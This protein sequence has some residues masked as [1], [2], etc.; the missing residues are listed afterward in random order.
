MKQ[1]EEENA[2]FAKKMKEREQRKKIKKI[3][4]DIEDRDLREDMDFEES[5]GKVG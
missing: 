5:I 3:M 1:L 2:L 4:K